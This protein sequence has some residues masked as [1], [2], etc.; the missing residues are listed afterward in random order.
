[1]KMSFLPIAQLPGVL[2]RDKQDTAIEQSLYQML[3]S[4]YPLR[5]LHF[6]RCEKDKLRRHLRMTHKILRILMSICKQARKKNRKRVK[7][8][9]NTRAL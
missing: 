2:I 6:G 9:S 8:R 5:N 1:M 7:Q 4:S 3:A